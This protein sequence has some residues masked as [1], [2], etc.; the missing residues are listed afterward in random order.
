NTKMDEIEAALQ[1]ASMR[2]FLTHYN[3]MVQSCF[4]R[5]VHTLWDR[6]LT[7]SELS[8]SNNCIATLIASQGRISQ[9]YLTASGKTFAR[10][11]ASGAEDSAGTSS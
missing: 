6:R 3:Q 7:D 8:C 4:S 1:T 5:C 2:E 10:Q 9:A 11:P